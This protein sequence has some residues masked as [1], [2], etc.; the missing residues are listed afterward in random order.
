VAGPPRLTVEHVD[1]IN[2]VSRDYSSVLVDPPVDPLLLQA[3]EEGD[4][5]AALSSRRLML[6]SK[7][8][9][10]LDSIAAHLLLNRLRGKH[11]FGAARAAKTPRGIVSLTPKLS[12]C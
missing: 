6:G 1:V 11:C 10:R 5:A 12:C 4:S 7:R 8:G 3:A 9:A 2:C